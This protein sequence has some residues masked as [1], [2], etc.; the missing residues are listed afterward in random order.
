M[1]TEAQGEKDGKPFTFKLLTNSG[2]APRKEICEMVESNLR[3]V[4]VRADITLIDFNQMSTQL[5]QHKFDAYVGGWYVA[6]KVDLKPIWH[7][8]AAKGRFNYV[9][10]ADDRVDEI[11][12][13]ARVMSDF[14]KAKPLWFEFQEILRRDQPYTMLYEPIGLVAIHTRFQNVEVNSLRAFANI[15]EW[16]VPK[17][18]QRFK[19][20]D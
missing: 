15:H 5:K 17:E 13:T 20:S 4:G 9:D 8:S 14:E 12:E 2:N 7:S 10:Y 18:Q 1:E 6:T 3:E 11:I 19:S 16:W